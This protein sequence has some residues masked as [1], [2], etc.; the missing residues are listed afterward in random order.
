MHSIYMTKT[1]LR[2]IER[3]IEGNLIITLDSQYNNLKAEIVIVKEN[4][5]ARLFGTVSKQLIIKKG[6][7][8]YLHGSVAGQIDNDGGELFI[9]K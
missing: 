1:E 2:I 7:R 8:V 9:Y 6:A 3:E 5:I 4:V